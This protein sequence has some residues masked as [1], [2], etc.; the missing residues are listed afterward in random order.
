MYVYTFADARPDGLSDDVYR[1]RA[2]RETLGKLPYCQE[3]MA[4]IPACGDLSTAAEK[5]WNDKL[6]EM[7]TK[8][9]SFWVQ[10]RIEYENNPGLVLIMNAK[11]L[12]AKYLGNKSR[13]LSEKQLQFFAFYGKPV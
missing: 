1:Y 11:Q 7:R 8:L 2:F 6:K 5:K 9:R 4:K 3:I 12:K 13:S 10:M